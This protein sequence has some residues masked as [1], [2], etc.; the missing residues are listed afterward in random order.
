MLNGKVTWIHEIVLNIQKSTVD[1]MGLFGGL[2]IR[3]QEIVNIE[4]F[5]KVDFTISLKHI[6][7]NGG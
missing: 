1:E 3:F 4:I 7:L 5:M 6:C 2:N